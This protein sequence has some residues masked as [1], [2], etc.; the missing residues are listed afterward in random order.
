MLKKRI[1]I[2]YALIFIWFF[3]KNSNKLMKF[4]F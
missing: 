2:R 3:D 4:S 1:K